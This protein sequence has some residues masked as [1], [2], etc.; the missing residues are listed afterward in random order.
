[1]NTT[2]NKQVVINNDSIKVIRKLEGKKA[3]V[4]TFSIDAGSLIAQCMKAAK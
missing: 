1:M 3:K 2:Q 4:A